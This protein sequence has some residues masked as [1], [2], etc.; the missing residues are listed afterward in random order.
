MDLNALRTVALVLAQ[1][2]GVVSAL[3]ATALGR[4]GGATAA[5]EAVGVDAL[6]GQ[7]GDLVG[8]V[9]VGVLW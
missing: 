8:A 7:V 2:V 4:A 9:E 3:A 6:G 1:G 5:G